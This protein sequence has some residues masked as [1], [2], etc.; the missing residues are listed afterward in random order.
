MIFKKEIASESF[1]LILNNTLN[2]W[3]SLE[4]I[5]SIIKVRFAQNCIV[6]KIDNSHR[7][8]KII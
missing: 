8:L 6:W 1:I 2:Y 7:V 4:N 5:K 3:I